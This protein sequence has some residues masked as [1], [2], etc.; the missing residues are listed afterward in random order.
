MKKNSPIRLSSYAPILP[1]LIKTVAVCA[2]LLSVAAHGK[3][4]TW[5][6]GA[7]TGYWNVSA[8]WGSGGTPGAGD[9]LVFPTTNGIALTTNNISS[10]VLNQIRFTG[11]SGTYDIRGNAFTLTNSILSTN[12]TG[13]NIIENNITLA[14]ANVLIVVSNGVSLTL[15]GALYGSVGVNKA[16]MG[17]LIYQSPI[18]NYYTGTTLV[19]G[20]T[21]QLDVDGDSAF[22][23]P[24]V[25]GDGTG[26][27]SPT[28]QDLIYDEISETAPITINRNGTLDLNNFSETIGPS[29]TLSGGTIQTGS[30]M[31]TL[32][33]N[34]TITTTNGDSY[35]YG[36]LSTGSGTL[37]LQGNDYHWLIFEAIVSGS[38]NI[39]QND[40]LTTGWNSANTYT[41][42]YTANG[43]GAVFLV[44]SLALGNINNSMTINGREYVAVYNNINIT[45]QSLTINDSG[46]I[47]VPAAST[48]SWRANFTLNSTCSAYILTNCALTLN[49][50][51]GGAGGLTKTGPGRLVYSG[52]TAN[53]YSGLTTVNEGELDLN[54]P[55]YTQAIKAFGPGLVIGDG[56]GSDRVVFQNGYQI[57]SMVTPVTINSSGVLNLNG[58]SDVIGPMTLNSGV[59]N[60][61]GGLL[62]LPGTVTGSGGTS[63][64]YGN[65][66]PYG[67]DLV[68]SN[69]GSLY[70][71][72]SISAN[73]SY[74]ITIAGSG[75]V[76]FEASNSYTGLTVVQSGAWLGVLNARALGSASSGTVVSNGANLFLDI[77]GN[78]GITNES[79]TLSGSGRDGWGALEVD[80]ETNTWA[81]PI[82]VNANSTLDSLDSTT[83]LHIAGPISGAGGLELIGTGTHYFEGSSAN[84]YAGVT[85]IDAGTTLVLNKSSGPSVPGNL[86]VSNGATVRLANSVQTLSTADVL[87]NGGGLFDFST[88]YTIID[89][90]RGSGTVNFGNLGFVYL[91]LNNGSSEFDGSFT[92]IGFPGYTVGKDGNGTFTIGGNSSYTTGV[93]HVFHGKVVIN[94]S[95][96]LIP[97]TVDAGA[98]LGGTGTIG[99]LMANGNISPGNSPGILTCSN[100]TWSSSGIFN[101]ELTG[102]TPGTDYDQLNVRGT[103]NLANAVLNMNLAFTKPVAVGQ[104]FTIIN[105]DGTDPITGIFAGYPQGSTWSQNGFTASISYFGGTGNDV[106]FTLTSLPGAVAGTTVTSGNGNNAIDPNECDTLSISITNQDSIAMTGVSATLSS[107]DPNVMITQPASTYA[108]VPSGGTRT[109][110]TP[111]QISVLPSF[112]CGNIIHLNLT[113]TSAS[114]GSFVVPTVLQTGESSATATRFDNSTLVS[115]PDLG[116]VES[117]NTV[118]GFSGPV[119]KVAVSLYLTH[120]R[121]QD[122]TNISL[123]GPDGTTV[124]LSAANGGSSQN[125]GSATNDASRTTFDD[126][127]ATAI[128]SGTAPFVGAFRP[129]SPLSAFIGSTNVN[130]YWRLHMADGSGGSVGTLRTWSLFLYPVACGSGGGACALCAD[131]TLY[132]NTLDASSAIQIGRLAR[133]CIIST[134]GSIKSCPGMADSTARHYQAYP[135]YNGPSNACITV[136]LT[137]PSCYL[138]SVAYLG[139]FDPANLCANYLGDAGNDT[140]NAQGCGL[141]GPLTYSFNV[142]SNSVFVVT[143]NEVGSGLCGNPYTL[144]VSGG[145]CRPILNIT[146]ASSNKVDLNWPT[147]AG[148]Y[149]LEATPA[150][151]ASGWTTVTN[152]PIALSNLF[153]VT[154][155]SVSPTNRFYRLHKP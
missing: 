128:T 75:Q 28:V 5:S 100:L 92:G 95:Q 37:T 106:V 152:E 126:A 12:T 25:I 133:N 46:E 13:N 62:G 120:T 66:Y 56:T 20:G 52:S 6:G 111:F 86:V 142:P 48:N 24:L 127:A 154:N 21:L 63:Y 141:S 76:F 132:T 97:V 60:T 108:D 50:P 36:H 99:V 67:S 123:I 114:H 91:G 119:M 22:G 54:K 116:S 80:Q 144:S 16:G 88:F 72:A 45:N 102:P 121:D 105:N 70:V 110:A 118:S 134:C 148:G 107:A 30:G 19:S 81:G 143:V 87:V 113:V 125:Y 1:R 32:S 90:L 34:S 77:P 47:Y 138:M 23:G 55:A 57:N 35:I 129:Q 31:L 29:L 124:M 65:V 122:L 135:F 115:I 42:N 51:I 117:T 14:T 18:D 41:G 96:P 58:Y 39:V 89:T 11:T 15:A 53:T 71:L 140:G 74:G 94:G 79:L 147:V 84:T 150:L 103:N 7:G 78:S 98:T 27:G 17:T 26:A 2:A 40:T 139:S 64:I 146:P 85:T 59:I 112:L 49:G 153:N 83:A 93:T 38:A 104:Q 4:L 68:F 109:N 82:I 61:A 8:N 33:A 145:D 136:A 149:K 155:S 73:S 151:P 101:L 10:L 44:N 131:G 69:T 43:S 9:T 130:G 137:D 3:T